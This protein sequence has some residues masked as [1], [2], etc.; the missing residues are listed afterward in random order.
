[1]RNQTH[2]IAPDKI[3]LV[4]ASWPSV[5]RQADQI[6]SRFY[7]VLFEIDPS[8][9]RLFAGVD[10]AAQRVKLAQ[11]L[12]VVVHALDDVDRLLAPLTHLGKRHAKYGVEY[13]HFD[14][15][16]QALIKSLAEALGDEFTP[17]VQTAWAEAYGVVA[18]VMRRAMLTCQ[19]GTA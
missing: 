4:R 15:V 13:H 8:A 7:T 12:A 9:G 18:M 1:M 14:S 6:T 17:E 10:M 2:V 11:A 5:A 16:G 3:M 19:T